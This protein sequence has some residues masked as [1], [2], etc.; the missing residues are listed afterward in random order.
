M[1]SPT[2]QPLVRY[3]PIKQALL[4]RFTPGAIFD[5]ETLVT[6]IRRDHADFT[7]SES[8]GA[9]WSLLA[10]GELARNAPGRL[11]RP[12]DLAPPTVV[13]GSRPAG[14]IS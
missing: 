2:D 1:T 4:E 14:Q 11:V 5:F 12:L 8:R 9:I 13:R 3:R 10:G 7:P 6:L